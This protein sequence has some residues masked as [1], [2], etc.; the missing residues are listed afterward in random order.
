MM[1]SFALSYIVVSIAALSLLFS[2]EPAPNNHIHTNYSLADTVDI[3]FAESI[4]RTSLDDLPVQI[5]RGAVR[6]R[7]DTTLLNADK[8]TRFLT[9]DEI[10]LE[11]NV[12][13]IQ[14]N[15]SIFS[16]RIR[17][18]TALKIGYAS[19]NVR[20][21]DGEVEVLSPTATHYVDEKRTIF[22]QNVQLIDSVTVLTSEAGEYFSEPKRAEFFGDV[23]LEE[24]NTYL[25]SDSVTYFRETE[26]SLGYGKVFIERIETQ[27]E[28]SSSSIS[29]TF[30]F[31]DYIFNDNQ[32]GYSSVEGNAF[33]FQVQEDSLGILRDSLFIK[34]DR[35]EASQLDSLDR[36][37]AVDSVKIW[38]RNFSATADS[39]VYD[40][41]RILEPKT[42]NEVLF[43]QNR[44]FEGP[45][46]WFDEYQL[47]GDSLL[48]TA[49]D[50]SIDSL[51]ASQNA[52]VAF[53]DSSTQK[54]NQLKGESLVGV[55][56][57][58]SLESLTIGPQAETIYH[59]K[60]TEDQVGANKASGDRI[61]LNFEGNELSQIKIISG[62]EGEYYDG[63]LVPEPFELTGFRWLIEQKPV[64]QYMLDQIPSQ[65]LINQ[66]L[67]DS[68]LNVPEI[69][70]VLD[71]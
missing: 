71:E 32:R 65:E 15:D 64:E 1:Q 36:L 55:F 48:A 51:F 59:Q 16:D 25:R 40:R 49:Y 37:I 27:T 3:L 52:F 41:M 11:G 33:L 66:R 22:D 24:D 69:K 61:I 60:S 23:V 4:E 58:D 2:A 19:G 26:I 12:L 45:I 13:I 30:I 43:E 62:I 68:V 57:Q 54:I 29:R 56:A 28:D 10:L 39:A 6:L 67:L 42:N 21:S 9:Q 35:L 18:D 38:Q 8:V 50:E 17:Y 31:G 47:S 44:L 70:E 20:L 14:E 34:S 7:Q 46:A 5:L 63:S 53:L